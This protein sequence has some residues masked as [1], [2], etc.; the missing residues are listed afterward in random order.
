MTL[1]YSDGPVSEVGSRPCGDLVTRCEP[2]PDNESALGR[3]VKLSDAL[4]LFMPLIVDDDRTA[5]WSG[6]ELL[7]ECE[8]RKKR[9]PQARRIEA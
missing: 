1:L 4:N 8:E 3:V 2:H 6:P 9:D 7:H 5:I